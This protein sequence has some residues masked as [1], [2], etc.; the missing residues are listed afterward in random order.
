MNGLKKLAFRGALWTL[1]N[2]GGRQVL[3]LGGNLL[4]T[5]LLFPEFFG[6]MALVNV[7]IVGLTLF[8]DVGIGVSIIQNKQGD[9]P[10][11]LHTAWTV[12]VLRGFGLWLL[13]LLMAQPMSEFYD[14]PQL[15]WL[16]PIVG[17]TTIIS[18]FN[19]TAIYLSE[20]RLAVKR[21]TVMELVVQLIQVVVMLGWAAVSPTI[22][23]LVVGNFVAT[24]VRLI[25]SFYLI[26]GHSDRLAW[27][28]DILRELFALGRWVFVS[29]AFTFM[30]EQADRLLLGKL[31]PLDLFGIYGIALV[32]SDVPRQVAVAM[33]GK[34]I[35]PTVAKL[36]D[37]PRSQLRSK[38]LQH[39]K[40]LLLLLTAGMVL[41]V[42]FGDFLI[43]VLYDDRYEAAAWMLPILALG[44]WPRLL[45]ATIESSLMA[46]GKVH[47]SAIGNFTRLSFTIVGILIGFTWFGSLGA[48]IAVALNDLFYYAVI[49]YGLSREQM[50][51]WMQDVKATVLLFAGIFITGLGRIV[52]GLGL[53]LDGVL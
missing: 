23:A 11:F 52:F 2:Y 13:C 7:F 26:P 44:I 30:A 42:T 22:W 33:S 48:V 5:R 39:R 19:S 36:T 28:R 18:G 47:Y 12:Q 20:R 49:G 16:I 51:C 4:L 31:F 10:A 29:T 1:I 6:L 34:V 43:L 41:M 32:L 50:G 15:T 24:I 8:S 14:K 38:L 35:F 53:P 21:L 25:W 3:R 37:L 9:Q 40:L 45:C 46:I 17:V 27:D